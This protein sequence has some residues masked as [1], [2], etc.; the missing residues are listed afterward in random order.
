MSTPSP[1]A[2]GGSGT[3]APQGL[4]NVYLPQTAPPPEY[5]EYADPASAHGWQNAYDET[6]ELPPVGERG[7]SSVRVDD[8]PYGVSLPGEGD[9]VAAADG[10]GSAGSRSGAGGP[11][12]GS[13]RRGRRK[14]GAWRSHRAVVAAGAVGA[15]SVAALIA[16]F[17]FSGSPSGASDGK[18]GR[19]GPAAGESGVSSVEPDASSSAG[20]PVAGGGPSAGSGAPSAGAGGEDRTD[21]E[22]PS[23]GESAGPSAGATSAPDDPTAAPSTTTE[24]GDLGSGGS[25]DRPGR[26]QG[27]KRPK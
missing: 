7:V 25:D 14:A 19:T 6:R 22:I 17:A 18:G 21:G 23:G 8:G 12:H 11:R 15:V 26:G 27:P 2:D 13:G 1:R 4:P 3:P 9:A 24:P 5:D 16:G 10:A 20:G